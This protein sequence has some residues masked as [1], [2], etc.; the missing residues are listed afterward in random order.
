MIE[1]LTPHPDRDPD[2]PVLITDERT[3]TYAELLRSAWGAAAELRR[4]GITRF[5][6]LEEDPA[7]VMAL[8]AG[9][10][11]VGAEACV[12]PLR[13]TAEIVS[14]TAD[15]F[16]HE[17]VLTRR[18]GITGPTLID[19]AEMCVPSDVDPGPLPESRPLLVTTTGTTG[20]PRGVKHDW[21][22]L[23]S[24]SAHIQPAP[25]QRWLLAY[26]LNQF[27][28]LQ[29]LIHVAA[30]H[31]ALVVPSELRPVEGVAAMRAHGVTHASGTPTF[32]RFALAEIQ[33]DHGP[34]PALR[35]LTLGGEA[36][37][38]RL[39]EQLRAT[40]TTA[41]ISQIYGASEFG[42]LRGIRDGSNGLPLS[43]LDTDGDLSLK[44]VDGMLWV[45]S[46]IG[47]L[48]YYGEEPIDPEAWRPTGDLAEIVGDRIVFRG[49]ASDVINVGGVKVHP[50]AVEARIEKV[51]GVAAVRVFGRKNAMVGAIVAA[52]IVAAPGEDEDLI[53]AAIR[54]ACADMP[55]AQR[56][57]SVRFVETLVTT[58]NKVSR[59]DETSD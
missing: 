31:A 10:S 26:G 14:E 55:P 2:A 5:A 53:D 44:V 35:Q 6:I 37:P 1:F 7:L 36:V 21:T 45:R 22:R 32:W 33:A 42:N 18:T 34:V 56:P 15:R 52:E 12:Y 4:R 8:L 38:D 9:S 20:P 24:G 57:R 41:K 23:L 27:G 3:T 11:A 40:F 30:S 58:G 43:V 48:G 46:R 49:R 13:A 16:D 54:A 47:M 25:D 29:I 28:G 39:L 51:P 19:P 59:R 17:Y 50:I